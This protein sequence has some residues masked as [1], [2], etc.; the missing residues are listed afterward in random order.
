MPG[1]CRWRAAVIVAALA[2]RPDVLVDDAA[3]AVAVRGSDGRFAILGGRGANFEVNYWLRADADPRAPADASLK[4]G[5]ACD[6]LGCVGATGGKTIAFAR[7]R[8]AFA[9]DCRM[10]DVVISRLPAPKGCALHAVVIDRDQ[11]A[12]YGAHA[13]YRTTDGF[14]IE[15]AYPSNRR[16]FMP[17]VAPP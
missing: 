2:P 14:R 3:S 11:L 10:A 16:P 12:R 1:W 6:G 9:D 15:T 13:L 4:S 8:D 7:T 5:T 17:Q